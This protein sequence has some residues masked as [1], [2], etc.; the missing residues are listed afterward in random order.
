LS[1]RLSNRSEMKSLKV[2]SASDC[3]VLC[4]SCDRT[5]L[6]VSCHVRPSYVC[7][8][9]RLPTHSCGATL[10]LAGPNLYPCL[11]QAC[12]LLCPTC[13]S[14]AWPFRPRI[15]RLNYSH[16]LVSELSE[17]TALERFGRVVSNHV[18]RRTPDYRN[19]FLVN[20]VGYEELPN[21]DVLRVSAARSFPVLFQKNRALVVLEQDIIPDVVTLGLQEIPGPAY[22]QHEVI[23]T[24]DLSFRRA[25]GV[26]LGLLQSV[27]AC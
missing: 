3:S 11:Y 4:S 17:Q 12:S 18:F 1:N 9:R 16:N 15:L 7:R 20:A 26:E 19:F 5:G 23:S 10:Y 25:A 8:F 6:F 22:C 2:I 27:L 13:H 14:L 24:H 21:V